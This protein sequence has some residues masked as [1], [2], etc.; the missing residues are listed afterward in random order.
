[1]KGRTKDMKIANDVTLTA[2]HTHTHTHTGSFKSNVECNKGI[3]YIRTH[4]TCM[5]G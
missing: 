4:G 1:M 3:D 5:L 2:V